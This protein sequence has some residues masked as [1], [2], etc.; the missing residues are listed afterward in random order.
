MNYALHYGEY[1]GTD[2]TYFESWSQQNK[3]YLRTLIGPIPREPILD[4]GCGFGLLVYSLRELGCDVC[5]I[6]IEDGQ[7]AVARSQG[8]PCEQVDEEAQPSYF[9][10]HRARYSVITLFDVLEHVPTSKQI[11][12]LEMLR[13]SLIPD[14]RLILQVPNAS[15]PIAAHMRYIDSTHT[16]SFTVDSLRFVLRSAGFH[17]AEIGEA[18]DEMSAPAGMHQPMRLLRKAAGHL[19]RGLWRLLYLGEFGR[20]GMN[21]PL[22]R[23]LLAIARNG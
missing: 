5:G 20:P 16:S 10:A 17:V 18:R 6:D 7:V 23:N 19:A 1:H 4:V 14:G 8:L 11:Y 12:F 21:I 2:K 13:H 22:S 15:S 3:G 9:S